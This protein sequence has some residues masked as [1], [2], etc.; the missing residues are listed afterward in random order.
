MDISG[1]MGKK[2]GGRQIA[3]SMDF[4]ECL[5][6]ESLVAVVPG[7]AFGADHFVRLSYATSRENI[8]KG[9]ARIAGFVEGLEE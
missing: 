5:L 8:E 3:G 7:I 9:I 2:S 4:T 1:L 6:E